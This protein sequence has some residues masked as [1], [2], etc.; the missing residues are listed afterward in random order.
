M[1]NEEVLERLAVDGWCIF[2]D[3][4]PGDQIDMVRQTILSEEAN[5]REEREAFLAQTRA[6]G[7]RVSAAGVG[8]V[9][10]LISTIP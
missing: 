1:K 5:Q 10:G 9:K 3:A 6:H 7:H 2:K 4:I 8:G